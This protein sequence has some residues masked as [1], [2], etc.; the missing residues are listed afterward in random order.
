[1]INVMQ[2]IVHMPLLNLSFPANAVTFYNFII[3]ISNFDLI[4]TDWIKAK[5]FNFTKEEN[6][7]QFQSMGYKSPNIVDN[8]GSMLVYFS[9]IF[10]TIMIAVAMKYFK[11]KYEW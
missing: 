3:D 8:M 6:D 11:T 4:P 2:L 9:V 1:M 5:L 7:S 10:L